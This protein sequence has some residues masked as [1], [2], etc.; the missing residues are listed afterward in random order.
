MRELTINQRYFTRADCFRANVQQ[1]PVGIQV[2]ST[3]AANPWLHRYVGPD[4]GRL[5]P[6][7]HGNTH[8]RPGVDVCASAYIG[9][10]ADG[11]VA[12]YQALPWTTRCWLSGSGPAGNANRLGY[13][14]F[15]ICED[16]LADKAYFTAAMRAAVD[17]TAYMCQTIG[18]TPGRVLGTYNG[19]MRFAVSDHAELHAAGVASGHADIGHWLSRY[20]YTMADFRTWV[21]EAMAEGVHVVYIDCDKR[22]E[23]EDMQREV[24]ARNGGYVNIRDKPGGK[25]TAQLRPGSIVEAGEPEDGWTPVTVTGYIRSDY[26]K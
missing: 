17:L 6:N 21:I 11:T 10:Q 18:T 12:V 2:H 19:K 9:K 13:I 25:A 5:G 14:G 3:G 4:D 15:E 8:N 22:E 16:G 7:L 1:R 24:Y 26:L 20:G 23:V